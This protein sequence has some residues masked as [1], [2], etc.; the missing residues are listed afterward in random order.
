MCKSVVLLPGEME[1]VND[2][3]ELSY[4]RCYSEI[5]LVAVSV[6]VFSPSSKHFSQHLLMV[7]SVKSTLQ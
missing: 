1:V 3:F 7:D 2:W 5:T 4:F 6:A